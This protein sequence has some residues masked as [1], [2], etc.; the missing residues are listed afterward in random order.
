MPINVSTPTSLAQSLTDVNACTVNYIFRMLLSAIPTAVI[1]GIFSK[2]IQIDRDRQRRNDFYG[3]DFIITAVMSFVTVIVI[4]LIFATWEFY[5]VPVG[6]IYASLGL[7]SSTTNCQLPSVPH[8]SFFPRVDSASL[9]INVCS[10]DPY[11][12][13]LEFGLM[14]V[15]FLTKMTLFS[16][17]I[18]VISAIAFKSAGKVFDDLKEK[19]DNVPTA[20]GKFLLSFALGMISVYIITRGIYGMLYIEYDKILEWAV[21]SVIPGGL[22]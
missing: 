21:N 15:L 19:R 4:R 10:S 5:G 20:M 14:V 11:V 8:N 18:F 17:P 9:G 7:N 22:N 1:L 16:I 3:D 13:Y 2:Y 6:C 12:K